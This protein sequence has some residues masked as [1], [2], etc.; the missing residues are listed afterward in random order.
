MF[1][2]WVTISKHCAAMCHWVY[3]DLFRRLGCGGS[4]VTCLS[5][6]VCLR[7]ISLLH[8]VDELIVAFSFCT[9]ACVHIISMCVM[10]SRLNIQYGLSLSLTHEGKDIISFIMRR[11]LLPA[12][13][14]TF[15]FSE[16]CVSFRAA[17]VIFIIWQLC[18]SINNF[19][20]TQGYKFKLLVLFDQNP[21]IF[22]LLSY[23][24]EKHQI[25]TL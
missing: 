1:D 21:N 6:S 15:W 22:V 10:G 23:D 7:P 16:R 13:V 14:L 12:N 2:Q 24:K 9:V 3:A 19:P 4:L 18:R 17:T 20:R 25:F 8:P 5:M 11:D